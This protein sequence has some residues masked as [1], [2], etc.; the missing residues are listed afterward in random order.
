MFPCGGGGVSDW[1]GG[2]M[3]KGTGYVCQ[4][5]L[6]PFRIHPSLPNFVTST[7]I[8][9]TFFLWNI[10][11]FRKRA[12]EWQCKATVSGRYL[13]S[14]FQPPYSDPSAPEPSSLCRRLGAPSG[15]FP[16]QLSFYRPAPACPVTSPSATPSDTVPV[17]ATPSSE[18]SESQPSGEGGLLL[19]LF[20]SCSLSFSLEGV[21]AF[22]VHA[23]LL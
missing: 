11:L 13:P 20:P 4:L 5:I 16:F 23:T 3:K 18:G 6:S 17:A 2:V 22:F 10:R 7:W 9:Y 12:L 14:R 1:L 8:L 21:A 19:V 15:L